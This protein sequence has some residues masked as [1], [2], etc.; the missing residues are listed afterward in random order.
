MGFS[1]EVRQLAEQVRRRIT[2]VKSEEATKQALIL[3]FFQVLGYDV[4][5]PGEVQPEFV[6]DFA[7]K[8]SGGAFEKVDY[9]IHLN[10]A[11]V[12]LVECKV[13]GSEPQDADGQLA[14]YFNATTTVK[15]GVVT[16]GT[17]YR[18]FTDLQ[19]P[20]VMDPTPFLEF[21]VL[22][23]TDR[24][25]DNVRAFAKSQFNAAAV[26]S[27]AEDI[28]Y[29][30]RIMA[31][32]D[33][34]LRDPSESFVR[35]LLGEIDLVSGRVTSKVIERFQP[36]VRRSIQSTIVEM[37]TR[38]FQQE[39][40]SDAP[41]APSVAPVAVAPASNGGSGGAPVV[42]AAV[43]AAGVTSATD[44]S[45][46]ESGRQVVTT[47]DELELFEAVKAICAESWVKSP[48]SYKDTVSYFGINLGKVS[49]WFV[50]AF[51]NGPKKSLVF[52][53]PL[54]QVQLVA[55]GFESEAAPET[56]GKARVYV[57]GPKDAEK[58]RALVLLAYEEECKRGE[59]AGEE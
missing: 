49:R 47:A 22:S 11:P 52:R 50:R 44:S 40:A 13:A 34:T 51:F 38:G 57:S 39:I 41:A 21:D 7:K 45:P 16:N 5:D 53:L 59:Q 25:A 56:F 29:T 48:V 9:A 14:R 33:R 42:P 55:R 24:D 10:G 15:V 27:Y 31:L 35:Y 12:M 20:N 46:G 36:I 28:I 32:V 4:Y 37:M 17:R 43:I 30:Q 2:N 6:S 8:K 18:F 54:E 23:F 58:L 3:P 1:D 19:A 26:Q